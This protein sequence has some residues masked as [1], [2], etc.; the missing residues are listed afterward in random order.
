MVKYNFWDKFFGDRPKGFKRE[1]NKQV[2]ENTL[3]YMKKA[4]RTRWI[5]IE[6]IFEQTLENTDLFNSKE[7]KMF[8]ATRG[9]KSKINQVTNALR[10]EGYPIISGT[11]NFNGK[12]GKGYRYADENCEDFIDMWDEKFSAWEKR[13]SNII[14]EK[15]IDI[16]LIKRIME[17]LIEQNRKQE[18]K[19]L[20]EILVK[21]N[22]Q[23]Q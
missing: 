1:A 5:K 8:F 15:L 14:K 7:G 12:H 23:K 20:E 10:K 18:S 4:G 21:Y 17:K 22:R 19:Q 2:K 13:K 16:E 9:I 6:E 3:L 11:I